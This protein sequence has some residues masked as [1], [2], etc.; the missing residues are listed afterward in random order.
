MTE[1]VVTGGIELLVCQLLTDTAITMIGSDAEDNTRTCISVTLCNTTA[2]DVSCEVYWYDGANKLVWIGD[3]PAGETKNIIEPVIPLRTNQEI[4]VKG[5]SG[6][7]VT[8]S[9][10][11]NMVNR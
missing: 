7:W 1:A 11:R 3:V 10:M 9:Y 6:I 5:A 2:G 4:R 8:L